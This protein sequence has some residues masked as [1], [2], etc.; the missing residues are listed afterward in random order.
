MSRSRPEELIGLNYPIFLGSLGSPAV[1]LD[2]LTHTSDSNSVSLLVA[3]LRILSS[4]MLGWGAPEGANIQAQSE[5]A[6][7]W[8]RSTHI[9][10]LPMPGYNAKGGISRYEVS[11]SLG[12]LCFSVFIWA[13]CVIRGCAIS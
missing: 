9:V 6:H 2:W 1:A 3:K 12:L 8:I 5:Q 13:D 11:P 10:A 4:I 7:P